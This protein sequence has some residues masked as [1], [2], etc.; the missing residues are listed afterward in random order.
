MDMTGTEK[1][2]TSGTE[3]YRR[4]KTLMTYVRAAERTDAFCVLGSGA[5]RIKIPEISNRREP[6]DFRTHIFELDETELRA[7]GSFE[8]GYTR[9]GN[10]P[11]V[12][13][14]EP[15]QVITE[16]VEFDPDSV[17]S[18]EEA[19]S[20]ADR[21]LSLSETTA[22]GS[23][24]GLSW[25]AEIYRTKSG[26]PVRVFTMTADLS[27]VSA[28]CGTPEAKP[29][30][31]PHKISRVIEEAEAVEAQ[32]GKVLGAVN[33]DFFDM[34]GDGHPS[35]LCVS[36]GLAVANPESNNPFFAILRTGEPYIGYLAGRSPRDDN[37]PRLEDIAEAI[38]G[39]QVIVRNGRTDEI[40]PLE[41]FGERTHPRTAYGIS[42]D[43][44]K[45][46]ATVVDGR[47]PEWSN[48]AALAE[49]AKIMTDHGAYTALNTDG[50]GSSTF[51]VR[52]GGGLEMLNHPADLV[53]PTEDLIRPL[54]D[55]LIFV[56]RE[57]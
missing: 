6:Y 50:G 11:T 54:F 53:R 32:G 27:R 18:Q 39:G 3:Y 57:S 44:K 49:L 36:M 55:S 2:L 48:G 35:G 17:I 14:T 16:K 40:A 5:S 24:G 37:A 41:P 56:E 4:G 42:E 29:V 52:A 20:R 9:H 34:F 33:G 21:H 22:V 28:I 23:A 26:E 12:F 51:I 10:R 31:E 7:C 47:R 46:I 38:G 8:V 30:F 25:V 45:V 13:F 15:G 19:Y 1:R 43:R